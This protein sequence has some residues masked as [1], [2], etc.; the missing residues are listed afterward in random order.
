MGSIAQTPVYTVATDRWN[1]DLGN[2]RAEIKV[3]E[4]SDAVYLKIQWRRRDNDAQN[5]CLIITDVNGNEVKNIYRIDINREFGELVFQ[6]ASGAGIYYVY[7]MP[8]I[9][10]KDVG[11]FDGDYLKPEHPPAADW[12]NR[13]E[14]TASTFS[15]NNLTHATLTKIESRTAFDSFYPM[16]VCATA[17]ETK[18][19]IERNAESFILFPEDRKYPIRMT[20]DLPYRWIAN[21]TSHQFTGKALRN[22][23]YAFQIGVYAAKKDLED[24]TVSYNGSNKVTCFNTGGIDFE[25]KLFTKKVDVQKGHVQALWFGVDIDKSQ[26]PGYYD[27]TVTITPKN[28][29]PQTVHVRLTIENTTIENRGDNEPW[30]H[31][32]LR[33]LNSALGIDDHTTAPYTALQVNGRSISSLLHQVKLN[34]IGLPDAII[35]NGNQVFNT[36]L[37]FIVETVKGV[38][39]IKPASFKYEKK[40]EGRV[41]WVAEASSANVSFLINGTMEF[42][43]TISY[44]IKLKALNNVQIKDIRLELPMKKQFAQYF[45]G[46]GKSGGFCPDN[47][48]WKWQGPQDSYWIGSV[49][50]GIHCELRGASYT[51]PM[52]NLYHPAP[53]GSWYNANNGGFTIKSSENEVVA[54]NYS[55]ERKFNAGAQINFQ[56]A[57]LLTPVK[58]P[59]TKNQ[60]VNRYYHDGNKP[61]P[62]PDDLTAGIK[63]LNVHQGNAIN[64]YINYPFIA[65]DSMRNFVNRWHKK[66]LKVKI[67]YTIRELTNQV[68]EL[69]ALRSLGNEILGGG[70]G[71]G[72]PW[73]REHLVDNYDVQWFNKINGYE[74]CDAAIITSGQSRW[75]NYYV[76]GLRWAVKNMDIDGLYLDDVSFDR[77]MLSR[78]R[79]VMNNIKPGCLLDLHSNTGFSKGPANQYTEFFPFIDKL[80]FGE[81]FNYNKMSPDNWMVEVSG[82]PFGLMGDMLHNGGNPWRGMIYGMT[83]RYPWFTEGV[84]CDPRDIWKVWDSFGIADAKMIGYW[85]K[86]A[87]VSTSN[88]K[89]L[90]TAYTKTGKTLISIASWDDQPTTIT[91]NIDWKAIGLSPYKTKLYAPAIKNF[92][93]EKVFNLNEP[94]MVQ[95]TKGYLLIVE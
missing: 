6:P 11:Y 37:R 58:K 66:G 3:D 23:Y 61:A 36:P 86:H 16:E 13:N 95:P 62:S 82:I 17:A 47:Y 77:K 39:T 8:Y 63:I 73:L 43:G 85:D 68:P 5:K 69:W 10:K 28:N 76:E 7:Y 81:S 74:E 29:K 49:D 51:G 84:T 78:M 50:A 26:K 64:P 53:P 22:E 59:D 40:A 14:L 93:D 4:N 30:R 80:W 41:S 34:N 83:V 33:W 54:T 56:F 2:H 20:T 88:A 72:Y 60:F 44:D 90:A 52:L 45:M 94:I 46:M 87:V 12:V 21:K 9:G 38:E 31:S 19:L 35:A 24:I 18:A 71:G 70:T 42:D 32:R 57:L 79:K 75:Y 15:A 89:V 91:L 92:Q 25:G 65:V 55:G 48:N 67:Y 1:E 27:F